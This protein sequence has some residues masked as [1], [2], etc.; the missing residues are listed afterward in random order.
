MERNERVV[1]ECRDR[2]RN[3]HRGRWVDD[4]SRRRG[5]D[6][7][8]G[9]G[10]DDV[11]RRGMRGM[12]RRDR[13][14]RRQRDGTASVGGGGD[15]ARHGGRTIVGDRP[16][17]HHARDCGEGDVPSATAA[18]AAAA[19][20]AGST[21]KGGIVEEVEVAWDGRARTTPPT[22]VAHDEGGSDFVRRVA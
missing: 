3:R 1:V 20:A 22:S 13:R 10:L 7:R 12:R 5:I 16:M 11:V 19:S 21:G 15:T 6:A 17:A 4:Y 8:G 9:R 14:S 2:Y 18:A